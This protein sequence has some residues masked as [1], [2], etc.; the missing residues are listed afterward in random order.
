MIIALTGTPGTGKTSIA[1]IIAK[2]SGIE[3]VHVHTYA[4]E[5]NLI[6]GFDKDR[7]S[8]II[9]IGRLDRLLMESMNPLETIIL[10]GHISHLLRSVSKII[11]LRCHPDILKKRLEKRGWDKKKIM[12]NIQ[13]EILDVILC[14]AIENKSIEEVYEMD[15]SGKNIIETS[16]DISA[17]LRSDF[18]DDTYRPGNTDWSEF[19]FKSKY[20]WGN[21]SNGS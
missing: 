11:V 14:E 2:Q 12:E 13:A 21:D 6:C 9:D 8:D 5:H 4:K 15:T 7:K 1:S 10:D 3:T 19:M 16:S 20:M 17:L 18:S